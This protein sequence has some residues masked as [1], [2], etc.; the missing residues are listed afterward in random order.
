M[1]PIFSTKLRLIL[2]LAG[3]LGGGLLLATLLHS[4]GGL[5]WVETLE[6]GIPLA[7]LYA[8]LALTSWYSCRALP[9]TGTPLWKIL[10][11]HLGASILATAV[12][13]AGARGLALL[14]DLDRDLAPQVPLL[15]AIGFFLY[16]LSAAMHYTILAVQA[17]QQAALQAQEAELRALKAQIN[18]HFLFNSLNSIAALAMMDPPMAREMSIRL[19]DFLRSTLGLGEKQAISWQEELDLVKAYLDVEKVRFG[20]RLSIQ[21]NIDQACTG[22]RV[23]PLLLQPLVENAVKHGIATLVDGGTIEVNSMLESRADGDFLC[24]QVRNGFDPDAPSSRRNGLG[25][26]NVRD[27]LRTR[28]GSLAKLAAR[29]ENNEFYAEMS[30]PCQKSE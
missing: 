4:S 23:P 25:L 5:A 17:S 16:G 29:T 3:W 27:R 15:I 26:R 20:S 12:W 8:F 11:N 22:C 13:L 19:S 24:V 30:V 2:Y 14:L 7:I 21:M 10:S 18:P 1:H 9:L 6:I 28:F